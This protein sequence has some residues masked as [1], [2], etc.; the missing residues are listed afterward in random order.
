MIVVF[1]CQT[2]LYFF[3]YSAIGWF[4][5]SIFCSIPAKKFINRGFLIGPLCPIYG[6]GALLV[7]WLLKPVAS[8][9]LLLF[10]CGILSTSILE[11]FTSYIMEKLFHMKWWDYSDHR[12]HIHGR[13]CFTNSIIF[14]IMSVL[15]VHVLHP[16]VVYLVGLLPPVQ[17]IIAT[18]IIFL[19][20]I[21]DLIISVLTILQINGKLQQ[22]YLIFEELQEKSKAYTV[23]LKEKNN[24]H[25]EQLHQN[26]EE[27]LQRLQ[28]NDVKEKLAELSSRIEN[29]K[30]RINNVARSNQY[31]H[32]RILQAFP[33]LESTRYRHVVKQIKEVLQK[34]R[35]K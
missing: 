2:I 15:V 35:K 24:M 17:L 29:L 8:N 22:F 12:F 31:L 28:A 18:G 4:C 33:K 10:L 25:F 9:L 7:I 21:A 34:I 27:R 5:E 19:V 1:I 11:Y 13:V 20:F 23:L 30:S 3:I 32:R 16:L 26:I 14:G 6:F